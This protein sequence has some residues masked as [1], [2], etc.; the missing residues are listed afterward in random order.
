MN[1]KL[2][3]LCCYRVCGFHHSGGVHSAIMVIEATNAP[4]EPATGEYVPRLATDGEPDRRWQRSDTS[5]LSTD[6]Q[7]VEPRLS[8]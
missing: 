5:A 6:S 8:N 3:G 7:C 4:T 2:I 1:T